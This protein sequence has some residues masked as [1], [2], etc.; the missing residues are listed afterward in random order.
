MRQERACQ[1]C[2]AVALGDVCAGIACGTSARGGA[3]GNWHGSIEP[4]G[5][6]DLSPGWRRRRLG[7]EGIADKGTKAAAIVRG[8]AIRCW[9]EA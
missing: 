7:M 8:R 9:Q 6:G 3:M 4:R 1:K 2:A 5:E